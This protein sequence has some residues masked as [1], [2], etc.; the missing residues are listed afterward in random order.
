MSQELDVSLGLDNL[1]RG[2]V[3]YLPVAPGR[4]E[5]AVAVRRRILRDRPDV[6]AVELPMS[7]ERHYL[8]AVDQL[9]QISVLVY[10]DD[11]DDDGDESRGVYVPI[12]PCDPFTEAVR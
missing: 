8:A 9:P 2:H 4:M 6:V 3:T 5:F 12:E 10:P 1:T 7:L 11:D